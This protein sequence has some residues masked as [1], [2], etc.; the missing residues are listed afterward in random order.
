MSLEKVAEL[1]EEVS[2]VSVVEEV[3]RLVVVDVEVA[4]TVSAAV[5]MWLGFP[6]IWCRIF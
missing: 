1:G 4:T 3:V 6:G 5:M 2:E